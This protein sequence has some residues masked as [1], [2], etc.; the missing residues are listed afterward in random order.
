MDDEGEKSIITRLRSAG[1]VFA[2]DETRLLLS[3][4]RTP[5]ALAAMVDRRAAGF[6]LEHVIGW[7]DFCDIRIAVEPGVFIPRR[8]TEFL[9][10]KAAAFAKPED[11]VVDLCCGTGAVGA[12]LASTLGWI[13]LYA[14]DIDPASVR[15]ARRNITFD[16]GHVYEGDLYEPLPIKLR[17]RVNILI[18]N[19]P[20]VPTELIGLLPHEARVHEAL[21]ALDGGADGLAVHRRVATEAP[22]WLAPGGH[23]L[24][25]T[26]KRQAL[27]TVDLFAQYGLIPQVEYYDELDATVI[28][29]TRPDLQPSTGNCNK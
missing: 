8:R 10:H 21:V 28:I 29:G 13:K 12:A 22:H 27:Q 15:C 26:S 11:I 3:E 16:G 25:E 14:T 5:A 20:Y 7:A 9:V 6:P 17:G 1:C 4:A 23:L 2:E 18:A 24:V 19:A